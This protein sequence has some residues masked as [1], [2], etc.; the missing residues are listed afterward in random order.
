M[1]NQKN[2]SNVVQENQQVKPIAQDNDNQKQQEV[3]EG[4]EKRGSSLSLIVHNRENN[5]ETR[6]NLEEGKE[7]IVGASSECGILVGDPYISGK[8]FSVKVDNGKVIV[9]DLGSTN[10]L[11]IKLEVPTE[12]SLGSA[13]LAGKTV[14]KL[15]GKDDGH[16]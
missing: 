9:N 8:H 2:S 11:Y 3:G 15:E 1:D 13:L 7:I 10:G 14:F 4:Q 5:V 6:F 16:S 12:L